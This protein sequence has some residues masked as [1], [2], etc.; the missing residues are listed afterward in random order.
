MERQ[1]TFAKPGDVPAQWLVVDATDK[2]LGRLA[3]KVAVVLMGKH[4]PQ[5]TPH[6]DVGDY[7]VITNAA[8]IKLTGNKAEHKF[9]KRFSGYP[10][11]LKQTPYGEVLEKRPERL[12]E[13]AVRRMLPK[14]SLGR[15]MLKKM[16]VYAGSE[17]PHTA[18]QCQVLEV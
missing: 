15:Q 10:G 18:Q 12:I 7:V 6:I 8:N 1:T 2:V 3:A 4:K 17:H 11:G 9:D 5:Y 13:L 14:N 16:K